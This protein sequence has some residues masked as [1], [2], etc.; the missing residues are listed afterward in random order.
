MTGQ[1]N[2]SYTE[3]PDGTYRPNGG[4]YHLEY[5]NG[6]VLLAQMCDTGTGT[7]NISTQGHGTKRELYTWMHAFIDGFEAR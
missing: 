2:E 5:Q 6:G 1:P 3:M 7:R 4:N